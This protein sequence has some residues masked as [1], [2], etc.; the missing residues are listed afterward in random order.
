VYLGRMKSNM[1]EAQCLAHVKRFTGILT[2]GLN[3]SRERFAVSTLQDAAD[4]YCITRDASG[5]G[6]SDMPDAAVYCNGV[7]C[8]RISYN[9][10]IWEMD[11]SEVRQY[12]AETLAVA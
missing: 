11:G 10:R 4:K 7:K 5:L 6:A 12:R 8:A 1:T 3:G 9:G 2:C